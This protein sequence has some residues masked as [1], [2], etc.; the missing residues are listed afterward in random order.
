MSNTFDSVV[1]PM[2]R[3]TSGHAIAGIRIAQEQI[4]RDLAEIGRRVAP[5]A[6]AGLAAL[7]GAPRATLVTSSPAAFFANLATTSAIASAEVEEAKAAANAAF[8]AGNIAEGF[9]LA[10]VAGMRAAARSCVPTVRAFDPTPLR[11]EP[12]VLNPSTGD[13]YVR[14]VTPA[15]YGMLAAVGRPTVL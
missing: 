15:V 3:V 11:V 13:G 5:P 14:A 9:R 12:V 8:R 6:P 10:Q 7:P 2:P 4:T 1:A